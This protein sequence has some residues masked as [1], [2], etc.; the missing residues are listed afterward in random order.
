MPP[1]SSLFSS[2]EPPASSKSKQRCELSSVI[3]HL[4]SAPGKPSPH[5]I[6]SLRC[7]SDQFIRPLRYVVQKTNPRKHST[8]TV[9]SLSRRVLFSTGFVAIFL[10]I[11]N[12]VVAVPLPEIKEP[13]VIR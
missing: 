13:D 11:T 3:F 4:Q 12:P 10:S 7:L 6:S 8:A 5:S 2:P 1:S 9:G